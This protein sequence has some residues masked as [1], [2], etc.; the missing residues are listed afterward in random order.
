MKY[1]SIWNLNILIPQ[2][3]DPAQPPINIKKRK[4]TDGNLP[5][6]LKSVVTYPVP[7]KIESTLKADILKF[8]KKLYSL[9]VKNKYKNIKKTEKIRI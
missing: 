6:K 9:L 2:V 5:H 1:Q 3:V 8:S 7:D 4:N